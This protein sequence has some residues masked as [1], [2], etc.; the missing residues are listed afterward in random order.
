MTPAW[1]RGTILAVLAT[2][3]ALT[4]GC[5]PLSW[6]LVKTIGPW[7][8]EETVEA[9]YTIQDKSIVILVDTKDPGL[10]SEFP[11]LPLELAEAIGK[12]LREHKACGPVVAGYDIESA[13]RAEPK[14]DTW[15]IAEVGKYFNVDLVLH[16]EVSEFRLRDNPASNV[17]HGYA[18]A[19]IRWVSPESGEQVWPVLAAARVV[20]GET[21]PDADAE[22]P[23]EQRAIL[24]NGFA[25]KIARQ[26]YTYKKADLS[27][28]PQV[29]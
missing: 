14:F 17:Y 12:N 9:E 3:A 21:Q 24:V 22:E 5:G 15:S 25:D 29:Q 16:V 7:M 4:A 20:R 10:T 26:F 2:S 8:P 27:L 1:R 13:R 19:A 28:R 11:R 6:I 23:G 18:E